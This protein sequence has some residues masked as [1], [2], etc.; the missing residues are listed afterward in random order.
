[1]SRALSSFGGWCGRHWSASWSRS[2]K[3]ASPRGS[4]DKP[5]FFPRERY[6]DY[7]AASGDASDN[8]PGIPGVG[9]LTA[10]KLLAYA[11]LDDYFADPGLASVALGRR[12]QKLELALPGGEAK[13]AVT[14]NRQLMDLRLAAANFPDLTPLLSR[15]KWDEPGF[16]AWVAEQRVAG[17]EVDVACACMAAIAAAR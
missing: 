7:R 14:R 16:R 4:D 3:K 5:V 12:N 17:L 10:A 2:S 8:L 13:E 6:L 9:T 15:G 1:M 11:P